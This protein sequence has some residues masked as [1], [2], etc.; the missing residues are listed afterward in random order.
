[1]DVLAAADEAH[2][3]HAESAFVHGAFG[4]VDQAPVVRQAE[5]V[6]GTEIQHLPT[7]NLD[8]GPLRRT[9]DPF[10]FVKPCGLDFGELMLQVLLDF[11]VHN[12]YVLMNLRALECRFVTNIHNIFRNRHFSRAFFTPRVTIC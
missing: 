9:D 8:L 1:M 10:P 11:T 12:R 3:R 5:V 2:G 4:G 6:V 7:C